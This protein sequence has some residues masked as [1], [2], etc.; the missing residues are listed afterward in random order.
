M[1]KLI[2]IIILVLLGCS[3]CVLPLKKH[4]VIDNSIRAIIVSEVIS[5]PDKNGKFTIDD[6]LA[7]PIYYYQGLTAYKL[8]YRLDSLDTLGNLIGSQKKYR[9]FVYKKGDTHGYFY[10]SSDSKLGN[11]VPADS[12]LKHGIWCEANNLYAGFSENII[13]L[14]A[15]NSNKDSG[16]LHEFYVYRRKNDSTISGNFSFSFSD[17]I[18]GIEYSLSKELDSLKSMKLYNVKMEGH[19]QYQKNGKSIYDTLRTVEDLKEIV[20]IDS[21]EILRYFNRYKKDFLGEE[22]K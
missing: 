19:I 3:N 13:K 9:F 11:K 6:T 1:S 8:T 2:N 14:V 20:V 15:T 12:M 4:L 16:T 21:A 22:Q 7:I 17:K 5:F 18:K 10:N